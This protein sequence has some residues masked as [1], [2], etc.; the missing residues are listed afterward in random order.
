MIVPSL[1]IEQDGP[2]IDL[3][4]HADGVAIEMSDPVT[5]F[6]Y[7][8]NAVTLTYDLSGVTSARLAFEAME[9]GDEPHAPLPGPFDDGENFD[10]VCMYCVTNLSWLD[11][12]PRSTHGTRYERVALCRSG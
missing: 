6:A 9:F 4:E 7:A 2:G 8:L 10:G 3:S 12:V 5:D 1:N 11:I